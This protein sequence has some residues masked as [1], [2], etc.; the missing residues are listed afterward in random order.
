MLYV[1]L[2]NIVY[3]MLYV[4][5]VN[6]VYS[7]LYVHLFKHFCQIENGKRFDFQ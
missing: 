4:H 3:S 6:I 5:L 2:V 1:H 7:M